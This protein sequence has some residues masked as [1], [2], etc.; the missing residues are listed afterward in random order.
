MRKSNIVGYLQTACL[1]RRWQCYNNLE[2][3]SSTD[4]LFPDLIVCMFWV[5][6][7]ARG[8]HAAS[9][10]S[11]NNRTIIASD[12]GCND[13][14]RL[15]HGHLTWLTM[16]NWS[17]SAMSVKINLLFPAWKL[18]LYTHQRPFLLCNHLSLF[19]V[20]NKHQGFCSCLASFV[21]GQV[22]VGC[23]R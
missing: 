5:C 19:L 21:P 22:C 11:I 8:K 14:H 17:H 15:G 13:R 23:K 4:P 12:L 10:S 1:Q 18:F 9:P 3:Q 16:T 20:I 7:A 2:I 6:W